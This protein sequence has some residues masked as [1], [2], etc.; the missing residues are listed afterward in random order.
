M[1]RFFIN[2]NFRK[3]FETFN[4]CHHTPSVRLQ[5][6]E[7]KF[8]TPRYAF[9]GFNFRLVIKKQIIQKETYT[10]TQHMHALTCFKDFR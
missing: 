6:R 5:L 2:L 4:V 10:H 1:Y 3:F 7:T 9:W 8:C